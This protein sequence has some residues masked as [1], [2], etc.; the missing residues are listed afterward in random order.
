M[1]DFLERQQE[2]ITLRIRLERLAPTRFEV[3]FMFAFR[4]CVS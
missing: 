3:L 2:P 4:L 1:T